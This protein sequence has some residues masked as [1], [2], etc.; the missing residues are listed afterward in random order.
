MN[1]G[2]LPVFDTGPRRVCRSESILRPRLTRTSSTPC[3]RLV[4]AS[5]LVMPQ[6]PSISA[7]HIQEAQPGTQSGSSSNSRSESRSPPAPSFDAKGGFF[8]YTEEKN[9][10]HVCSS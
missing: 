8:D 3:T 2:R 6:P 10:H 1:S 5:S 9:M 4:S 7:L